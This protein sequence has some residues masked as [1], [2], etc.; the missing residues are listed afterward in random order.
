[1]RTI[2][3]ILI[4][5]TNNKAA[6][7]V[8]LLV[9]T[10]QS[11]RRLYVYKAGFNSRLLTAQGIFIV[12]KSWRVKVEFAV[13]H[14]CKINFVRTTGHFNGNLLSNFK[15]SAPLKT[16]NFKLSLNSLIRFICPGMF[17]VSRCY[18]EDSPKYKCS[19]RN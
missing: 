12:V 2:N 4:L 6:P 15:A 13:C 18:G 1:M 14:V 19:V 16:G 10:R 7:F 9:N 17:V 8:A 3:N 11:A 5:L